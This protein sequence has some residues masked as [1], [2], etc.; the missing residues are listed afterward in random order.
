MLLAKENTKGMISVLFNKYLK[1]VDTALAV[2]GNSHL[3]IYSCKYSKR[4]YTQHQLMSLVLLK[5]YIGTD[6]RSTVELVELMDEVKAKIGLKQVPHY[7]TLQKFVAR[8]S[9]VYFNGLLQ[10]TLKLFYSH[11]ER[12][13]VT[14]I[15][16]SGFTSGHCSYYYSFRTGKKRRSFLKVSISV[17]TAKFIITGF[18]IS[19]KPTHDS[20]HAMTLLRQCHK[21]RRSNYYVMDKGYDSESIHSLVRE[22]L[23]AIAMIPLRQ[24]KRSKIK[25]RYRRKMIHEF[26]KL[27]YYIRNLVESMFSAVKRK[28]DD[29][30]KARKHLNQVKELKIKLLVQN[31][32]RYVKVKCIVQ[33]RISTEPFTSYRR[34]LLIISRHLDKFAEIVLQECRD[35]KLIDDKI[36]IWDRRFFK[37][38]CNGLKD[39]KTGTFSDPDAGHYVKKTGKYSILSGTGYTDTC[40]VDRLFG[41]PVYWDAVDASKND[42]TIFQETIEKCTRSTAQKPVMLIADAGPDSHGSNLTVLNKQIIPVIAARSNSVGTVLKTDRCNH[43][44]AIYIPRI[45]HRIL[46]K[47]YD[48]RTCVGRK[49]SNEVV[50]YNRSKTLTRGNKWAKLFVSI[51]NITALLTA[52]AAFKVERLD[53]IR[54]PSA[55]RKLRI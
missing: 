37:C 23:E 40:V 1:F 41:L 14:A 48:L 22:E 55:F 46:Q 8:I 26:E 11:G 36:W 47:I 4:T 17:D 21:T 12:I 7:T 49:N 50:G 33:M 42:N 54:A 24:R 5:E 43:F 20:K 35:L 16:S 3:Q 6:Y 30:I 34:N 10:Q 29:Q 53:L 31:L 51:S 52:L 15:D 32:D 13:E 18:K 45:Y 44:R 9:S 28:Y 2:S 27:L 39:K 19:G 25:G 38:N